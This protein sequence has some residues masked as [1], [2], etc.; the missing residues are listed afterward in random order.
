MKNITTLILFLSFCFAGNSQN[1]TDFYDKNEK[2]N[3]FAFIGEKVSIEEFD[4]NKN[5]A[6]KVYD[7][8]EKDSILKIKH[9]MDRA[10]RVKY[11]ILKN[12]FNDLKTDTI[13]FIVYDH[14][15]T[16]NFEK[17]KNVI[18]Y[19]SKSSVGNY[20]YLQKYQY[21]VVYKDDKDNWFG[22][23]QNVKSKKKKKISLETIFNNKRN[24]V[25]KELF[26]YEE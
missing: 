5:N 2:I 21:D 24:N 25:F 13:E 11:K 9:V 14:Y 16:P 26:T 10:F 8:V 6:V 17:Y 23:S 4:P 18:L 7:P 22:Y 1:K 3:L 19:I 20:Y 15:G 12:I